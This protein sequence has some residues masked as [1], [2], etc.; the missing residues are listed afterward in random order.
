MNFICFH[1]QLARE[2]EEIC[3]INTYN[4]NTWKIATLP[5]HSG[6]QGNEK[7]KD[8]PTIDLV[9]LDPIKITFLACKPLA[10]FGEIFKKIKKFC[11]SRN[12]LLKDSRERKQLC[13]LVIK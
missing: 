3:L 10:C 8:I 6:R 12:H 4:M 11:Q 7:E 5:R 2:P 1:R 13:N 9:A